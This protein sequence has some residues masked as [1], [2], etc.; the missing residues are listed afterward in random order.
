[1]SIDE[2]A[3]RE[4]LENP[5]LP[6]QIR[7]ANRALDAN[8]QQDEPAFMRRISDAEN[9]ADRLAGIGFE[10]ESDPSQAQP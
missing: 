2:S 8:N 1:M 10:S 4:A 5:L 6:A 3:E 9:I 7:A